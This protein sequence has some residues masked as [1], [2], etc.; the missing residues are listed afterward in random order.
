MN[1]TGKNYSYVLIANYKLFKKSRINQ[2]PLKLHG[3]LIQSRDQPGPWTAYGSV[4]T[5]YIKQR[6]VFYDRSTWWTV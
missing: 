5:F 3:I 1:D 4:C 6:I 2:P